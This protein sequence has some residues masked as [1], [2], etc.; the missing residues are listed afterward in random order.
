MKIYTLAADTLTRDFGATLTFHSGHNNT[1]RLRIYSFPEYG[2]CQLAIRENKEKLTVYMRSKTRN[3]DSLDQLLGASGIIEKRYPRDGK[4]SNSL[5]S[6]E[7][8]PYLNPELNELLLINV[9][10]PEDFGSLVSKYLGN[11]PSEAALMEPFELLPT[12]TPKFENLVCP[13]DQDK[14]AE[15]TKLLA[16]SEREAVVKVRYGQGA[17][18]DELMKISGEACWMSGIQ[19]RQLLIASH[20]KPWSQSADDEQARGNP[21][22]GLLLSSLWDAAFDAG[23]IC[24]GTDWKILHSEELAAS[25]IQALGITDAT[26]LPMTFQTTARSG[27]LAYH[28]EHCFEGWRKVP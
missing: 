13:G 4:P 12:P 14:L 24:F 5:L 25:A 27:F 21:H 18:R 28:R 8:A 7:K 6:R 2:N 17:F 11:T 15:E 20:I 3:G 1:A 23:L 19:G 26:A 16:T 10:K 9:Q 22:N